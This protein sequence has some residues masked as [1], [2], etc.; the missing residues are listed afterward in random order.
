MAASVGDTAVSILEHDYET[1]QQ[2]AFRYFLKTEHLGAVQIMIGIVNAV[3]GGIVYAHGHTASTIFGWTSA[4]GHLRA[5]ALEENTA[6]GS[7]HAS[8][9][10]PGQSTGVAGVQRAEDTLADLSPPHPDDAQPIVHHPLELSS[11]L[12]SGISWT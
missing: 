5:T 6:L 8:P 4:L 11:T 1:S 3:L 9:E 2:D 12:G 7:L 10:A